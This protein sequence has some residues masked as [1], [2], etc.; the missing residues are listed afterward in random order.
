M[1][2]KLIALAVAGL[3]SSGVFAQTNVTM[4][5]KID[6]SYEASSGDFG[7]KTSGINSG[8]HD[9]SRIG[10]RGE[11]ALGNGMKV[12]FGLEYQ[13]RSD[14]N[15]G[16]GNLPAGSGG[17]SVQSRQTY[18]GLSG[19]F[20]EVKA[21]RVYTTGDNFGGKYDS[22]DAAN[23][24]SP[25]QY[26]AFATGTSISNGAVSNAIAYKSPAFYDV[27][28]RSFYGFG[29][30]NAGTTCA[31][32]ACN[33]DNVAYVGGATN[34]QQRNYGVG[35]DYDKGPLSIGFVYSGASDINNV[36]GVNRK[37]WGVAGTYDFGMAALYGTYQGD[38]LQNA[39]GVTTAKWELYS[40]GVTVPVTKADLLRLMYAQLDSKLPGAAGNNRGADSWGAVFEHSLSKRTIAYAGYN[41][42]SNDNNTA[43]FKTPA[44]NGNYG[45][46]SVLV[47][48]G[49][50]SSGYGFGVIHNF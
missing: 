10:F 20:G 6:M 4:Y 14:A 27:T 28:V 47:G 32:P 7:T 12:I 46:S 19:G 44:G 13:L 5:G 15:S 43:A 29:A 3:A 42:M 21:G 11:E 49:G 25:L 1:Q 40:L 50:T 8:G 31:A 34:D 33:G 35:F 30:S 22:L 9:A 37:D 23:S 24:Y 38:K 45:E 41:H 39:F 36:S 2:K 26:F 18:V 17:G 48:V 16:I